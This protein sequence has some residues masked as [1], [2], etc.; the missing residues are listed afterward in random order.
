MHPV[1]RASLLALALVVSS[2]AG[3]AALR[4]AA[5][6]AA[7]PKA[8]AKSSREIAACEKMCEVAGDAE[9]NKAAVDRCK[10]DCRE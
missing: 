1:S 7:Q 8:A 4:S 10:K 3:C 5:L 9:S 2:T 6:T